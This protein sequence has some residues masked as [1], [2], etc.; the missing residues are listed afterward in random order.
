LG[1][2]RGPCHQIDHVLGERDEGKSHRQQ[3]RQDLEREAEHE[4]VDLRSCLGQQGEQ[5]LGGEQDH[6]DRR[7]DLHRGGEE[8]GDVIGD[9]AGHRAESGGG[10]GRPDGLERAEEAVH[11]HQGGSSGEEQRRPHQVVELADDRGLLH[12]EGVE[13]LGKVQP[14]EEVDQAPR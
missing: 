1:V 10:Q 13:S 11:D 6:D 9:D 12:G 14:G 2:G 5:Y 3:G 8:R 7:G 4:D